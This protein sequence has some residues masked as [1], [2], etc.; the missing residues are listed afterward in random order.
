MWRT[1]PFG[2]ADTGKFTARIPL[3]TGMMPERNSIVKEPDVG[4]VPQPLGFEGAS[5]HLFTHAVEQGK[6]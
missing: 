1:K 2:L 6:R 4:S 5:N 3:L